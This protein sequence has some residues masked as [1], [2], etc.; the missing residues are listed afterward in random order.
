MLLVGSLPWHQRADNG[1]K[2]LLWF[3][4]SLAG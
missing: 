1:E 2:V 4:F 3:F